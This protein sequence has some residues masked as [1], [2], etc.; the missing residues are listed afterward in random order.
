MNYTLNQLRV[1]RKVVET[2]SITKAAEELFMTQPAVSI[3]LKN[4][5]DQFD[6]PLTELKGRKIQVTDFGME[7]AS[8]TEKA[9]DQL[10]NL[11]YK[12]KEYQGVVTGKLKMSAASTGKYVIPFFLSQFLDNYPGIDLMLDVTNKSQVVEA[13][14]NKE[15]DFAVVSV[16]PEEIEVEEEKLIENKLYLINHEPEINRSK[17]QIFREKGSATRAEMEKYFKNKSNRERGRLELTSNEAVKQ[18]VVAGIGSSILPLIGIKN[19]LI[20]GD[21]HI[22]ERKGLPITTTWRIIW[23]KEKQLSPA[24]E[25]YLHFIREHKEEIL[26]QSFEWYLNY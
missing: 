15:I 2:K 12:T 7:I 13:L 14:K 8:I 26:H 4:F 20:N 1:F 5:Q 18:A 17:P 21:L 16:L 3:Q 23:L 19:E 25:A 10:V 11:Q 9:L 6:I 22:V 24:A